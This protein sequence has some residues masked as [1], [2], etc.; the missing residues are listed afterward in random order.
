MMSASC[1]RR[2]SS[3]R[4]AW[5]PRVPRWTS[6][7]NS[8][9]NRRAAS[10]TMSS[11]PRDQLRATDIALISLSLMTVSLTVRE[12]VFVPIYTAGKDSIG[13]VESTAC[14]R[15]PL[16]PHDDSL[17]EGSSYHGFL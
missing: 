5:Q 15:Q 6:E 16:K 4:S 1:W 14:H 2:K 11:A 13:P 8:A 7:I 10:V 12:D 9:R 17:D 3:S